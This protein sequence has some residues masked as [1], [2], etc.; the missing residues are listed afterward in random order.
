[1][2]VSGIKRCVNRLTILMSQKIWIT[3]VMKVIMQKFKLIH[4]L[5]RDY[6]NMFRSHIHMFLLREVPKHY[7]DFIIPGKAPVILIPGITARWTFMKNLGDKISLT[8]H[9]IYVVPKL[10]HNLIDIPTA[11]KTVH[12]LLLELVPKLGHNIPDVHGRAKKVRALIESHDIKDIVL[13]AHSKGGLIGKYLLAHF[14]HDNRIKGMVSI[15]T[16]FSGSAMAKLI[17]HSSFKEIATD[18]KIIHDLESH[19][20]V[21]HKIISIYPIFDNHVWAD[22]GSYLEGALENIQI[23]VVGH[24]TILYVK[25]VEEKVLESIEKLSL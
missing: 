7:L 9:P 15:A 11:A 17:P 14:N 25:E 13:V 19:K 20:A 10:G 3:L 4:H 2:S 23:N 12:T 5:V 22:K 8:G 6:I 24:H 21:N 18:S 16:P 1:V